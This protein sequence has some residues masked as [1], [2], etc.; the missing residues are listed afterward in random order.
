V[1]TRR[2]RRNCLNGKI[3]SKNHEEEILATRKKGTEKAATSWIVG[4]FPEK[5]RDS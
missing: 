2:L 5:K 1:A 3:E 4:H